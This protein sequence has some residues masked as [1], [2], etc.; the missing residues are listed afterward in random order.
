M[1]PG[2]SVASLAVTLLYQLQLHA[3]L[4]AEIAI[5]LTTTVQC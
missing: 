3:V 2:C 1:L 4:E 5:Y